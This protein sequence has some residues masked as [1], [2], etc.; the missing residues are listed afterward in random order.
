M[1]NEIMLIFLVFYLQFL[2]MID[3]GSIF[4]LYVWTA[5]LLFHR[6]RCEFISTEDYDKGE[7]EEMINMTHK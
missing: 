6:P 3:S 2:Y 5:V 4:Y 7:E 1:F